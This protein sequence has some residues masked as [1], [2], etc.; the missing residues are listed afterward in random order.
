M[1]SNLEIIQSRISFYVYVFPVQMVREGLFKVANT[2][3][4]ECALQPP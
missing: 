1:Q 4:P 3:S 2:V